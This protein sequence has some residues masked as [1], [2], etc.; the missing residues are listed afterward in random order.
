MKEVVCGRMEGTK[1]ELA[2]A[3]HGTSNWSKRWCTKPKDELQ[4]KV[5]DTVKS[6]VL[7]LN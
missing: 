2:E 4:L 1:A 6:P 3:R 5:S 7:K